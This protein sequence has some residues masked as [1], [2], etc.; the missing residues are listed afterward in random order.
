M[1]DEPVVNRLVD[2]E[3][4]AFTYPGGERYFAKHPI[5]AGSELF[6]NYGDGWWEDR[7][8]KLNLNSATAESDSE[9]QLNDQKEQQRAA[10]I[11][12]KE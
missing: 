11:V 8:A 2:S 3:P 5:S 4:G 6:N 10:C 7:V 9:K 12:G 1:H